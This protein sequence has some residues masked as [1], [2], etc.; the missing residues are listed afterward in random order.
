MWINFQ[1]HVNFLLSGNTQWRIQDFPLGGGAPTPTRAL[2]GEMYAKT[3]ELDP[4]RGA[5]AASPGSANDTHCW[6]F[7]N[8]KEMS[9]II[10]YDIIIITQIKW[11]LGS[12]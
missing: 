8:T 1:R 2:F 10:L 5:P 12:I 6:L 7:V 3:K 9:M 11:R 4:I